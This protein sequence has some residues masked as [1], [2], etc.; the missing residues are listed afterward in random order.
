MKLLGAIIAGGKAT[1]FGADKAA[2]LLNG[3]PLIEHVADALGCQ[4][5]AV[6][7]CGRLWPGLETVWDHPAPDLGPLGGLCGA[8][9]HAAAGGFDAV[10]TAGCDVLPIPESLAT[11]LGHGPACI[12]QQRLIGLWPITLAPMLDE[13]LRT[14]S[15]RSI[16]QWLRHCNAMEIHLP[17]AFHNI[18]TV[19]DLAQ[20]SHD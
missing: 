15:D 20:L 10:L 11:D 6:I 3:R 4:T 5:D 16:R 9:H 12:A 18:N 13:Y 2:A 7:V 14:S 17:I 8:L 19:A 1:R